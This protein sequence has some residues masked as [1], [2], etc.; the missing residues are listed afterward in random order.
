M[1]R[2]SLDQAEAGDNAGILLR[3]IK[4]EDVERGQVLV[5][6]GS[7]KPH[8]TFTV[9]VYILKKRRRWTSYTYCFRIPSTILF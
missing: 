7:I 6:P 5:K 8:R 2:K 1:F 4:K 3:G 9:K